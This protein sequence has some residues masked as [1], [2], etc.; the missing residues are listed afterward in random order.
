MSRFA[1]LPEVQVDVQ[2]TLCV[3]SAEFARTWLK[4]VFFVIKNAADGFKVPI[5][6]LFFSDTRDV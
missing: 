4:E 6:R 2:M 3:V 5:I 1:L